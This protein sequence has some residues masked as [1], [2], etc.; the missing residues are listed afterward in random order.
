MEYTVSLLI[1]TLQATVVQ[2][3]IK[4]MAQNPLLPEAPQLT[5]HKISNYTLKESILWF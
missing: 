1:E 5:F 3:K 4:W 2:D